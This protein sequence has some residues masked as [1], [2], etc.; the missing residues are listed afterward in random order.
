MK[1][2]QIDVVYEKGTLKLPRELPLAEG[3]TVT[4]T[5]HPA[6]GVVGR[7]YGRLHSTLSPEELE[8]IARDPEGGILESP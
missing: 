8:R 1:G 6:T 2:L 4:I 7:S 5:I 3:Q